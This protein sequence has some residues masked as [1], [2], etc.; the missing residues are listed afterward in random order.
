[1]DEFDLTPRAPTRPV[2]GTVLFNTPGVPQT[3]GFTSEGFGGGFSLPRE[4]G[5]EYGK[6]YDNRELSNVMEEM[7]VSEEDGCDT[8]F[9]HKGTFGE[10]V[11]GGVISSGQGNTSFLHSVSCRRYKN[12]WNCLTLGESHDSREFFLYSDQSQRG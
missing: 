9:H 6:H 8:L 12:V 11:C 4:E 3:G 1:M 2:A 7:E 5:Q 10:T